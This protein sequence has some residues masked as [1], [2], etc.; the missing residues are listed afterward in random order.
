MVTDDQF[1]A[2]FTAGCDPYAAGAVALFGK[3][4]AVVT[5]DDRDLVKRVFMRIQAC[6]HASE[7]PCTG[8]LVHDE[9]TL[10]PRHDE[11]RRP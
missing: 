9:F 11:R 5:Q 2:L 8:T 1:D 3:D 7:P 10:C 4:Q 6:R